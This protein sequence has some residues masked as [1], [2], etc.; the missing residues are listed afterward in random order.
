[1]I[2]P[3]TGVPAGD[4]LA[5]VEP[6]AAGAHGLWLTAAVV[7]GQRVVGSPFLLQWNGKSW[8]RGAGI[9]GSV[10]LEAMAQDGHGGLWGYR[11]ASPKNIPSLYHYS[12]GRW[13][14]QRVPAVK[15][16]T[17]ELVALT[18]IPET[19]AM[20]AGG[21]MILAGSNNGIVGDILQYGK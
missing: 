6:V 12:N 15:G 13:R 8:R 11:T 18:W 14:E 17:P 16:A 20:L 10:F 3:K 7:K 9:P 19:T 1:M 21:E 2:R 4:W 5:A